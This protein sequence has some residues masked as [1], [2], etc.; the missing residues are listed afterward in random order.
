MCEGT[1]TPQ[2]V[3]DSVDAADL[4]GGEKQKRQFYADLYVGLD[5]AIVREDPQAARPYFE[6]AIANGWARDAGYGPAFMW[7]VARLSLSGMNAR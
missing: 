2:Q 3:L 6:R 4:A 7:H 5:T 1:A